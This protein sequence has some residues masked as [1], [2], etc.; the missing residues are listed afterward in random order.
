[1]VFETGLPTRHYLNRTDVDFTHLVP[2][3]TVTSC[4]YKGITSEYWSVRLGGD[5]YPDLAWAYNFPTREVAP[6]A[7][8]IAFYDEQVDV[9]VDGRRIERPS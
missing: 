9:F 5:L 8:M 2:S 4:P 6:I 1:M 3:G 7:G